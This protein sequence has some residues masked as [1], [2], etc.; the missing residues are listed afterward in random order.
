MTIERLL[1][2]AELR[3]PSCEARIQLDAAD[4]TLDCIDK[5]LWIV[6]AQREFLSIA[7]PDGYSVQTRNIIG[8][9]R[10]VLDEFP[11][12]STNGCGLVRM[13]RFQLGAPAFGRFQSQMTIAKFRR[14]S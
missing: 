9:S 6:R 2:V 3:P 7:Q 5:R 4:Q 11:S 1:G 8:A 13:L 10:T 12:R 14:R